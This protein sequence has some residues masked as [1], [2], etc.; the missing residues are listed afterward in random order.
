MLLFSDLHL[1]AKKCFVTFFLSVVSEQRQ[2]INNTFNCLYLD[3]NFKD[4]VSKRNFTDN[5]ELI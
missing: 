5:N 3:V 1:Y 4:L 2:G